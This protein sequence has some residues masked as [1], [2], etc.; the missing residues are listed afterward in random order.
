MCGITSTYP[1][2]WIGRGGPVPWTPDLTPFDYFL[3][4][5]VKSMVYGIPVT[6]EENLIARVHGA[7]K[8]L[9]DNGTYWVMCV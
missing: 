5:S 7:I 8:T 4:G 3:W 9:K 1:N 2:R 6:P